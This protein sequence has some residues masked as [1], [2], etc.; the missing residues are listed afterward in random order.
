MGIINGKPGGIYDPELR[1]LRRVCCHARKG[2]GIE[3]ATTK[4]EFPYGY[5]AVA[6]TEK[7]SK[8][9]LLPLLSRPTEALLR[10]LPT[11]PSSTPDT[12]ELWATMRIP[13]M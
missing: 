8:T 5:L 4:Y 10:R 12:S 2:L 11:M 9:W 7:I 1:Y 13:F 6:Q 3:N